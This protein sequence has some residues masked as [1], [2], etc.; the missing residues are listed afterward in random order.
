MKSRYSAYVASDSQYIMDTTHRDNP[1]YT[2]D[3]ES[4]Q[5]SIHEFFDHSDFKNLEILEY[6]DGEKEAY[7]TFKATIYQGAIDVSFVEKSKFVKVNEMW[8]YHSGEH[9]Q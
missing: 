3:I 7:V 1:E 5:K 4:W 9:I 6:I 8:L 2:T